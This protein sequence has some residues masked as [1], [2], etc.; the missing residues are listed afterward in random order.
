MAI[1]NGDYSFL[2][3]RDIKNNIIDTFTEYF[4]EEYRKTIK[5]RLDRVIFAPY[6]SLDYIND[7][8]LE[9]IN[10]YSSEIYY[11]TLENL[12]I[13]ESTPELESVLRSYG[14]VRDNQLREV[15]YY[16]N[17]LTGSVNRVI[18]EETLR[19]VAQAFGVNTGSLEGDRKELVRIYKTY[20]DTIREVENENSCDVFYDTQVI[21][22]NHIEYIQK[23]LKK[24][25]EL[26]LPVTDNDKKYINRHDLEMCDF[27]DLDCYGSYF[28]DN[29]SYPGSI[30]YFST[31]RQVELEK[32]PAQNI[33]IIQHRLQYLYKNGA[34]PAYFTEEE[35]L[36]DDFVYNLDFDK[37]E[38]LLKEYYY[39]LVA[40]KDLIPSCESVDT[41][42]AYRTTLSKSLARNT[43]INKQLSRAG[44]LI[45]QNTHNFFATA[46]YPGGKEKNQII[47]IGMNFDPEFDQESFLEI[48]MH[49][50][51][52]AISFYNHK[53]IGNN[54][55]LKTRG[56][57][58]S[59]LKVIDGEIREEVTDTELDNLEEYCNQMQ[60]LELAE[61]YKKKFGVPYIPESDFD[62]RK[63][64][65][66]FSCLYENFGF[67]ASGF[68]EMFKPELK[69]AKVENIP[70]F[71][72]YAPNSGEK[73]STSIFSLLKARVTRSVFPENYSS[74]K[75]DY[76][77]VVELA[78]II[79]EYRTFADEHHLKYSIP[80]DYT[81]S[82]LSQLPKYHRSKIKEFIDRKD[83]LIRKLSIDH[84][85]VKKTRNTY[86]PPMLA[87]VF[88]EMDAER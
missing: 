65:K 18:N 55:V 26:G 40:S 38:R 9:H 4:G 24:A 2:D 34:K 81:D 39:Q 37:R 45:G 82:L 35:I 76:P 20:L 15:V 84:R 43:N 10:R 78:K 64:D 1:I 66:K 68:Y 12:G 36:T 5:N 57:A 58:V 77:S 75:M 72:N 22:Y 88:F 49:E 29:I 69:R 21:N 23:L 52:H 51:D 62:I 16:D 80:V 70:L 79:T 30:S 56:V 53:N 8:Y 28:M 33:F 87:D 71:Y 17:S 48:L 74:G 61:L 25:K 32:N 11:R 7:Y 6:H 54:S 47:T 86:E 14:T 42:E 46:K 41:L 50:L 13:K 67:L 60:T 27:L 73:S 19:P 44:L 83:K 59:R 85:A 3:L 63:K 31:A